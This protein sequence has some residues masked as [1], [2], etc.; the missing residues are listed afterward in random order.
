MRTRETKQGNK[1]AMDIRQIRDFIAVV[2]H[3]SFAAAS[4]DLRVSQPGLGYQVKQLEEE[5]RVQL[6]Q[7][8]ARGVSLTSA[9]RVFKD[10]AEHILAAVSDA[11]VAMAAIAND[12]RSEI[13]IGLSPSPAHVLGPLLLSTDIAHRL[14]LRLIEGNSVELQESVIRGTLDMAICL[15]AAKPPL[16]NVML[17]S[18]PLY[19]IGP[20]IDCRQSSGDVCLVEAASYPLVIGPRGH[21]TRK[22]IEDAAGQLGI[23]LMIEQ[24][25]AAGSLR[26]SLI[27]RNGSYTIAAFSMFAEEIKNG[28]LSARRIIKPQLTLTVNLIYAAG[29]NPIV[30]QSFLTIIQSLVPR[31][32]KAS[33]VIDS[34]S[35]AAE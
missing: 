35:I 20:A 21:T 8:H 30:E 24:E 25:L 14:K 4:R 6:L 34:A 7:R 5:L 2:H 26:R 15:T 19:L 22:A 11:K 23:K 33:D 31:T 32:P 12:N 28:L 1:R 13:S 3:E 9:G 18:E 17:Y 10:H 16:K 29:I 27:L